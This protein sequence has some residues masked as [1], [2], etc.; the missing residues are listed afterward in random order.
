MAFN[1]LDKTKRRNLIVLA[2]TKLIHGFGTSM[3]TIVY[4]PFLL[5][6]TNSIVLTGLI[7]SIG[8]IMQFLPMPIVGKFSDKYNRKYILIS[9]IPLYIIGLLF[10]ILANS[11]SLYYVILG[12]ILYFL[13]FIINNLNT[14][15]LVAENSDR[16]KG[17]IFGFMFF[18]YF[19][20]TI[21][22][23]F[24]IFLG[25]GLHTKFYFIFFIGLLIIEGII[26]TFFLSSGTQY[27]HAQRP[28]IKNIN[29][30]KE[31]MWLKVLKTK[32]LRTIL[33]FFTLDIFAYSIALSIYSGGLN[34]YYNLSKENIA[35]ISIWLNIGNAA[36]Q[37]PAGRIT[38]KIGN[39]KTLILSQIFGFGFF[40]T[41]IITVILWMNQIRNTVLITLSIGYVL[42]ALSVCTFIPAEQTIMTNLGEE[43]KSESYG[44]ISFFRGIG[45]I[46][47]GIL[48]GLIVENIHYI[49]PF[50]FSAVGVIIELLFLL[51]YF[52][53]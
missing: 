43:R 33:I 24:F 22:G 40:F 9:S 28:A 1:N 25:K 52:H 48:G 21:A 8:S 41:N 7:V 15:F 27:Y 51:F 19:A 36:F 50:I 10:L 46:P 14:Q 47:T 39:K 23:S 49:A 30:E 38:D 2:I 5:E 12:I 29:N 26:F 42:L 11:Y 45:L 31:N 53:E 13:G 32:N 4:Q 20:G 18:S 44:I 34:D 16:S 6:L 3:F 35:F 37:I 17:M